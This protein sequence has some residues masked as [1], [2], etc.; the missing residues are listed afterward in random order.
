M[1]IPAR[2][3]RRHV[4]GGR[5]IFLAM[6]ARR[7]GNTPS[8]AAV[9]AVMNA[10]GAAVLALIAGCYSPRIREGAPCD[11]PD[12]CPIQLRCVQRTCQLRDP[13]P[14]DAEVDAP[15]VD[16]AIDA[17]P[18]AMVLPCTTAG[19]TCS[20]TATAFLCSGHCWAHCTTAVSQPTAGQACTGWQGAP[21]QIDDAA[22][23]ACVIGHIAATSWIGLSQRNDA[24][25]P[26]MGWTWNGKTDLVY[27]HWAAGRPD[28]GGD[29]ENRS[30][31][32]GKLLTSGQWDDAACTQANRFLCKRP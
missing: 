2:T 23:E 30:E 27:T 8:G 26:G 10:C 5:G 20:G 22:E 15:Y 4:R 9:F 28:D 25:A 16:A 19:L 13:P 29:G 12:E 1:R 31:Q 24:T 11:S 6:A 7:T 32:C 14:P 3:R 17:P 21:G 18:D